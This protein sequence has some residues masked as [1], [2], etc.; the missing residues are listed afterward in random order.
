MVN[1][2]SLLVNFRTV[3]ILIGQVLTDDQWQQ[4]FDCFILIIVYLNSPA[5]CA[6]AKGSC[7]SLKL[8]KQ[9]KC[10]LWVASNKGEYP[11]HEAALASHTGTVITYTRYISNS[12]TR[13]HLSYMQVQHCGCVQNRVVPCIYR[14]SINTPCRYN[15]T[16]TY[17]QSGLLTLTVK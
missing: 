9:K 14:Y 4:L 2:L 11:I 8:L 6:A 1:L 3:L 7:T 17:K 12:Y 10:N 5:H 13:L 15:G 16:Y